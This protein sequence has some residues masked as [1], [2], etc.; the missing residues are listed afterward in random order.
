MKCVYSIVGENEFVFNVIIETNKVV[1]NKRNEEQSLDVDAKE[2][3]NTLISLFSLKDSWE[4]R[5]CSNPL[6]KIEFEK[7][8]EIEIY[9]FDSNI[10][11][12]FDLFQAYI[13][14][15]LG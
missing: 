12:N 3:F 15:L 11:E 6:Y 4:L 5:A 7:D 2:C 10:P 1:L 14:R 8:G 9:T 13:N